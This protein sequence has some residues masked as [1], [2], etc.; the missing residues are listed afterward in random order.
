MAYD[1]NGGGTQ[2]GRKVEMDKE[3]GPG[4]KYLVSYT[5]NF[6]IYS[7]SILPTSSPLNVIS[8]YIG[9]TQNS[10][11]LMDVAEGEKKKQDKAAQLFIIQYCTQ[12]KTNT[13]ARSQWCDIY[14]HRSKIK[15]YVSELS[16][17]LFH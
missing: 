2:E 14:R 6:R 11:K 1:R 3:T 17:C 4:H 7:F 5:R 10:K 13:D 12:N 9:S 8:C 15:W 16:V